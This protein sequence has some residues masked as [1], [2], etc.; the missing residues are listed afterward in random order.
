MNRRQRGVTVIGWIFLLIP[1]ALVIFSAIRV[2]T[3]Y[4]NYYRVVQALKATA[5]EANS[6]DAASPQTIRSALGRRFDTGYVDGVAT[7]DIV[8][9]KNEEGLWALTTD[10]ERTAKLF[11]NLHLLMAFKYTTVG[12]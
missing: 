2:S 4:L 6:D 9:V 8:V 10:Y 5:K 3:D 12:D 11:A 1:M 7:Q